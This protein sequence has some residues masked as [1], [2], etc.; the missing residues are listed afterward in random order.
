MSASSGLKGEC[1]VCKHMNNEHNEYK[2]TVKGCKKKWR[3]CQAGGHQE[4]GEDSDFKYVICVKCDSHPYNCD[5]GD[6]SE[7]KYIGA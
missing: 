6:V 1:V 5:Y 7:Y 4:F 2:C 3:L